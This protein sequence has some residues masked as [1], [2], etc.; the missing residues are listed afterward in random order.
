MLL[1]YTQKLTPR[2]DYIFKQICVNMLGME[3]S[4][5]SE[6]EK[7]IAHN[8]PK[9]S[10]A[11]FPLGSE[12]FF[13]STDL[14][15]EREIESPSIEVSKWGNTQG[16]F[17][18]SEKS[19]L[20]Y[21]VFAASFYLITRYEEYLP[22]I[23]DVDGSF[24]VHQS[25]AYENDFLQQPIIDIWAEI[26]LNTL[27]KVFPD[28]RYKKSTYRVNTLI[29]AKQ[30]FAY[31]NQEFVNTVVG[32]IKEIG[33]WKINEAVTRSQTLLGL[34]PDPYDTFSWVIQNTKMAEKQLIVFFML[35]DTDVILERQNTNSPKF[36]QRVKFIG[37]YEELGLIFSN[38]AI[39]DHQ[40]M[41]EEKSRMEAIS[42]R[43]VRCSM[44]VDNALKLP[45]AYRGLIQLEIEKDYSMVY[46]NAIG[47]RAGTCSEFLFYDLE[48]EVKTPLIISPI[49]ISTQALK[50][51]DTGKI[52][53][54]VQ[55]FYEE[56]ANLGGELNFI[57]SNQD[58]SFTHSDN[59]PFWKKL[60]KNQLP[61]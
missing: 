38:A 12:L 53:R 46:R 48:H 1:V 9:I 17:P 8:K 4:F 47:Y 43:P 6:I 16:F 23:S 11:K 45:D 27:L 56:I 7:F 39:N 20:P 35:G 59:A 54:L 25:L 37:D 61:L 34:K 13:E 31:A 29:E 26:F 3:I 51:F 50:A 44:F 52:E 42:H 21:D 2:I 57:F 58:F 24:P 22:Y 5:T 40:I 15:F 41:K 30:P 18:T 36:R 49:A 14:L 28:L 60:F 55:E 33:Q 32:Y 10:Y 19:A